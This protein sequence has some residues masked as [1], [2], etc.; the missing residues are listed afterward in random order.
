MRKCNDEVYQL[1]KDQVVL[2]INPKCSLTCKGYNGVPLHVME[3]PPRF[4]AL[5][6]RASDACIYQ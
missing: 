3:Q 2:I 4:L 6:Y 1:A 5:A